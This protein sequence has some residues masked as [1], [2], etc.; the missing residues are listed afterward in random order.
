MKGKAQHMTNYM[1]TYN[2]IL[3][4]HNS[5]PEA[6]KQTYEM[7]FGKLGKDPLAKK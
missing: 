1:Q 2:L 7:A 4:R 6:V 5:K 3:D